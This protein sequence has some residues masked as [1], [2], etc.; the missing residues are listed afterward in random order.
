MD[1]AAVCRICLQDSD[2][3]MVSIY[4]RDEEHHGVSICEKIEN[5]SG[6]TVG[7]LFLRRV[8]AIKFYFFLDGTHLRAAHPHLLEMSRVSNASAQIPTDLP[9]LR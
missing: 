9:A 6:I 1:I 8:K 7:F 5:C 2:T 4:E 3:H